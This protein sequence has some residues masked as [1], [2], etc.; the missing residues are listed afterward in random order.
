VVSARQTG[1][2]AFPGDEIESTEEVNVG[3]K[4]ILTMTE[5]QRLLQVSK[6]TAYH[7]V[8]RKGFPA[9]RFGRTIRVPRKALEAWLAKQVGVEDSAGDPG[10]D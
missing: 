6:N 1:K 5:V 2:D 10:G 4:E 7:L 3:E 9:V 8:H